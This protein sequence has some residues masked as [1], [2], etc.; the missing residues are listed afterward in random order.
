MARCA[1]FDVSAACPLRC[2]HCYYY[3]QPA[4][5]SALSTE[6]YLARLERLRDGHRLTTALWLGGEPLARPEL[7]VRAARL[8]SRNAVVTSGLLP[9]P[10]ELEAGLL[11]SIDGLEPEH[12]RLRGRG[13]FRRTV[14]ALERLRPRPFALQVTLTALTLSAIDSL[15][16]LVAETHAAG[17][18]VGFYTGAASSPLSL[19]PAM[20]ARAVERLLALKARAPGVVLS[21]AA[22]L[23][24]LKARS[25]I[26]AAC[27]YRDSDL[28][29]DVRL[30]RKS[31]CTYGAAADCASCGCALLALRAASEGGDRASRDLLLALFPPVARA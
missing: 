1:T 7:L 9:V 20:R 18:L 19:S 29:F 15:P 14:S 2:A 31:P 8:F 12:D 11:V 22:S 17:A 24:V 16:Q 28:A 25:G 13:A 6:T 4:P 3:A 23:E 30:E 26:H 21:S 5:A 27:P 10:D